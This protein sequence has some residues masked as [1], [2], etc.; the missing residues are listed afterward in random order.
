MKTTKTPEELREKAK[1]YRQKADEMSAISHHASD[2]APGSYVTGASGRSRAMNNRRERALEKTIQYAKR[3]VAY[4][5]KAEIFE[6]QASWIENAPKRARAKPKRLAGE[7]REKN[8]G[9]P[10]PRR[11]SCS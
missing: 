8:P 1:Y 10:C 11:S 3:A 9:V 6:V 4:R 5:R 2:N 7:K